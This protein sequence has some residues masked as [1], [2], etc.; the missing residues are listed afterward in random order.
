MI[1]EFESRL[2]NN[3]VIPMEIKALM[4]ALHLTNRQFDGLRELS[5]EQWQRL[6]H[7]SDLAHVSLSLAAL[8]IE[9]LPVWVADRLQKNLEDNRRRFQR[10]RDTYTEAA[11]TLRSAGVDFIVIKGFTLAPDFVPAPWLRQQS[12]IDLY[13]APQ[14]IARA[15][16][17][18]ATVGY[19]PD[20]RL[21]Y[22]FADHVPTLIRKGEWHWQGNAFD[23]DMP[24]SIELHFCLWNRKISLLPIQ[25]DEYFMG[26][27][28]VRE[29]ACLP[30][31]SFTL[32]DQIGYLSMHILRNLL[33]GDCILHHLFE[34]AS[35]LAARAHDAV[36]WK[37]WHIL[38]EESLRQK[39]VLAFELARLWFGCDL[40]ATVEDMIAELPEAQLLWL[41]YFTF[42]PLEGMFLANKDALW[43][44]WCLLEGS[45]QKAILLRRHLF[46]NQTANLN[47]PWAVLNERKAHEGDEFADRRSKV[48]RLIEYYCRR[49]LPYC[50][51]RARTLY[52]GA[53][54]AVQ[55]E[56]L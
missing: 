34:L 9:G 21:N 24:L 23:P 10:V 44:H 33:G 48:V 39:E 53:V 20:R 43:L 37:T 38:H 35:F 14:D 4:A 8:G 11:K 55:D 45:K 52:R 46:P 54:W 17:A 1:T 2:S 27:S 36:L 25:L 18:L 32:I 51:L 49:L 47:V 31:P 6:F 50:A 42:S 7:F 12:D 40:P 56:L 15:E 19:V 28:E 30:V 3:S 22:G 26:R 13:C 29:I 5:D 41:R 16:A